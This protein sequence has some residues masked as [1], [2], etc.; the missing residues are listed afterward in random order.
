MPQIPNPLIEIAGMK[1]G[2][3]G[4]VP[5]QRYEHLSNTCLAETETRR[6]MQQRE[7]IKRLNKAYTGARIALKYTDPMQL[8]VATILSAQCTDI[9]VNEVTSK[10]F[11]KYSTPLDYANA[12]L[13]EFEQEIR[14]T[15]F[16]HN[17]AKNIIGTAK[18]IVEKFGNKV[19]ATMAELVTLPGVARK[20]ANIVL[21]NAYGV[22]DGIAVDTHVR[23]LSQRLGLTKNDDPEKIEQDLMKLVPKS[24]WGKFS[25][26]L[27]SHG[28]GVCTAKK[29]RCTDCFLNDICPSAFK[30]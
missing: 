5:V 30:V 25:Y 20:T 28:R 21:F 11:K 23:R 17:K 18:I 13:E 2:G 15:G 4:S 26:L 19:P 9:K 10:L 3:C 6:G 1:R 16:Y 8:L 27:I 12:R 29:A 24:E 22:I 14:S 7:I